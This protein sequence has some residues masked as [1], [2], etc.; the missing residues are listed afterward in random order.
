MTGAF[1]DLVKCGVPFVVFGVTLD[2]IPFGGV[3]I[4][5]GVRYF[6]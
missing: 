1:H 6:L 4:N 5:R 3:R 2:E